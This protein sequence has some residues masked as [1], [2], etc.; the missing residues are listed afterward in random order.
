MRNRAK[1]KLCESIIESFLVND[2]VT[3]KCGQIAI[4]GGD[5]H[6]FCHADDFNN[7]MRVDDEGN[8]IVVHVKTKED[9][10]KPNKLELMDMLDTMIKNIETLPSYSKV[11]PINHYDFCSALIILSSILRADC[12]V[13]S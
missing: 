11:S 10:K 12:I 6:F 1:C 8:T 3:C 9:N 4:S 2:Y 7:F 13:D 5:E